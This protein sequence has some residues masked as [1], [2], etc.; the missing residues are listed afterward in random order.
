LYEGD[1]SSIVSAGAD[2]PLPAYA[3]DGGEEP[4]IAGLRIIDRNGEPGRPGSALGSEYSNRVMER[5]NRLY[6]AHSKLR[7]GAI[8]PEL[9]TGP[10]PEK[11][12]G[13]SR[14]LRDGAVIRRKPFPSGEGNILHTIAN[15]DH[16]H[17]TYG[18]WHVPPARRPARPFL[19]HGHLELRHPR[20]AARHVRDRG[21]GVRRA[22][23]QPLGTD[24]GRLCLWRRGRPITGPCLFHPAAA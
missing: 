17:F 3:L 5:Q 15:L 12:E 7:A 4:Q 6:L 8:G 22:L 10:V 18:M 19:R 16:H 20:R 11:L 13:E 23:A 1:G 24:R 21:G 2:L 14:I 9:R